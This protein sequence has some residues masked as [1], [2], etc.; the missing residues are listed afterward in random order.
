MMQNYTYPQYP[1]RKKALPCTSRK[2]RLLKF[3]I[4]EERDDEIIL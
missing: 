1:A 3:F 4:E 2:L